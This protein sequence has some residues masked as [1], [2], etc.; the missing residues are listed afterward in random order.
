MKYYVGVDVGGTRI[1]FGL[2]DANGNVLQKANKPTSTNKEEIFRDIKEFIRS[3]N[4]NIEGVG[5][6]VPGIIKKDGYMQTSGAIKCFF[7]ANIKEELTRYLQ[8]PVS[9]SNDGKSVA[10]AEKWL[11]AAIQEDNFVCL[12]LGT[13]IG[14][15]IYVNGKLHRGL[16]GLAGEFGIGLVGLHKS[17]YE[18]QSFAYHSA[19]VGGLCRQY[20][21]AIK[22]R[23]LDAKTI[24]D[25]AKNGDEIAKRCVEEFYHAVAILCINVAVT[26]APDV[27][28]LGGGISANT[29][30]MER[31][32]EA[33]ALICK[34]YHVLSLVEM[35]KIKVCKMQNL[36]GVI[37]AVYA[38]MNRE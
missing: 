9:V 4:K 38:V 37:G 30:V 36:A 19:T 34:E 31:I 10:L 8:L 22:K 2:V 15:A 14:G 23:V 20:S 33:Y 28:L 24:L 5:L 27:I 18:Q 3:Q 21:Y 32:Q 11:G 6:S 13:A 17:E 7:N 26:I 12:T 25:N 1:K 29:E 35:P 16:G